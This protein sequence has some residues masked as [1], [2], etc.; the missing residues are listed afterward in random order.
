MILRIYEYS[1][2]IGEYASGNKTKLSIISLEG[3]EVQMQYIARCA[4]ITSGT[5]NI[6]NPLELMRQIRLIAQN[7]V[8]ATGVE[9]TFFLHPSLRFDQ[10]TD[11]QVGDPDNIKEGLDSNKSK[12]TEADT[13]SVEM[14]SWL[15]RQK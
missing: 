10:T 8:I 11:N 9:V 2:Q 13:E 7:P 15:I 14:V 12:V 6:L 5:I 4:Q 3:E 1:L